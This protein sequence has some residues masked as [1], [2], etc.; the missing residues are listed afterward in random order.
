MINRR[1][2][3]FIAISG[4]SAT[5][6]YAAQPP[7]PSSVQSDGFYNTAM[8]TAALSHDVTP[9]QQCSPYA[10][11]YHP[12][13]YYML[14]CGNTA[15]GFG[16]LDQNT[17]GSALTA[18]GAGALFNSTSGSYN[19]AVGMVSLFHNTTGHGNQGF[20]EA[21]LFTNTTGYG[22]VALG[23][24]SLFNNTSGIRNSGSG[25]AALYANTTGA[26][27]TSHGFYSML[28]NTT[29]S[30]N[31]AAGANALRYNMT[32]SS[33][34]VLG[35]FAG[36]QSVTGNNNIYIGYQ[37]TGAASEDDVT[38]IGT[39]SGV[40]TTYIAGIYNSGVTGG[41]P[42]YVTSTGQLGFS[43]SSERFKTDIVT[44]G[45]S[46]EKLTQLRPVSF[47]VKTDPNGVLQ[48]GLIAEEVAKVFPELVIRDQSGRID[49][50]RYDELAPMLLNEVQKE[51][52][53]SLAQDAAM[54]AQAKIIEDLKA[55]LSKLKDLKHELPATQSR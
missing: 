10:F 22:N 14:G 41:L 4:L 23:G 7:N 44:M 9:H 47:H 27:N 18:F 46:T 54:A 43:A 38:R 49:G 13:S 28:G 29:G 31:V 2:G 39:P 19:T 34:T 37:V 11:N 16:A 25:D 5:S 48:Y 15:G 36:A 24:Y 55:Q 52:E 3:S 1:L 33:N 35:A 26:Y 6:L 8:G 32:G 21:S 40:G 42:V 12:G 17:T 53:H 20:G 51:H 45:A 30:N 50:V